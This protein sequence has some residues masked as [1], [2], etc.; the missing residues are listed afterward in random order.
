MGGTP[1]VAPGVY[2]DPQMTP[3]DNRTTQR[4]NVG[5]RCVARLLFSFS[6][7]CPCVVVACTVLLVLRQRSVVHRNYYQQLIGG[8]ADRFDPP[9][10][11]GP[12]RAWCNGNSTL[13]LYL[14]FILCVVV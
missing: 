5:M 1:A 11:E 6:I 8:Y 2:G 14:L 4:G 9:I 3:L 13:L 10:A 12:P 7:H